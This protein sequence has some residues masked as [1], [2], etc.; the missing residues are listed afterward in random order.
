MSTKTREVIWG[1]RVRPPQILS[2]VRFNKFVSSVSSSR[3]TQRASY[4]ESSEQVSPG[5]RL[6]TYLS[7]A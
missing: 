7:V 3:T 2:V 5:D 1:G 4:P 6:R